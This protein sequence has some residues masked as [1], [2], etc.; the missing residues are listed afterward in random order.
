MSRIREVP[1]HSKIQDEAARFGFRARRGKSYLYQGH[2]WMPI[3]EADENDFFE[4]IVP[5]IENETNNKGEILYVIDHSTE[6]KK[7]CNLKEKLSTYKSADV[8]SLDRCMQES[9]ELSKEADFKNMQIDKFDSNELKGQN[10]ER[11]EGADYDNKREVNDELHKENSEKANNDKTETGIGDHKEKFLP[12]ILISAN[13]VTKNVR[14]ENIDS[15][16]SVHSE[17][18]FNNE[19]KQPDLT[20]EFIEQS[21][22]TQTKTKFK[23]LEESGKV[24]EIRKDKHVRD[25][26]VSESAFKLKKDYE[27][28]TDTQMGL[29]STSD[30]TIGTTKQEKLRSTDL[31]KDII[32]EVPNDWWN[33]KTNNIAY[34][35][36]VENTNFLDADIVKI[37]HEIKDPIAQSGVLPEKC[38]KME[39]V[40]ETD[41]F[42]PTY[43]PPI[44][45][46]SYEKDTTINPENTIQGRQ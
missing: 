41:D 35:R 27:K 8:N 6:D 22:K 38:Y 40:S 18:Q 44:F 23:L 20:N 2:E 9:S 45:A 32:D 12:D 1:L 11:I 7:T 3:P 42:T 21:S 36:P 5:E 13:S 15:K 43:E 39:M 29:S 25:L 33:V 4:T 30:H 34:L 46:E 14:L 37:N 26:E 10:N 19:L 28:S 16:G 24:N 17:S 31:A